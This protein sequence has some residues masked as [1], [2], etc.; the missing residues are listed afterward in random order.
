MASL[1]S[2]CRAA[3]GLALLTVPTA[4]S[5]ATRVFDFES[6]AYGLPDAQCN[7]NPV[8]PLFNRPE[9]GTQTANYIQDPAG[10]GQGV[11]GVSFGSDS[12]L[13][14]LFAASGTRSNEIRFSWVDPT[15]DASW[16]RLVTL[17]A[18]SVTPLF[19]RP[20]IDIRPGSSVSMN[21]LV[22]GLDASGNIVPSG[23]THGLE[24]SLIVRETGR[25][26]PLGADGGTN[27]GV[28]FVGIASKG[29][30]ED[31][32]TP[33]GGVFIAQTDCPQATGCGA[34]F[35]NIKWTFVDDDGVVK[36]DVSVDNGPATRYDIVNFAGDG[37]L[38]TPNHRA[39]LDSLAIR[40]PVNDDVTKQWFVNIDDIVID[41]PGVVD[42]VQIL[43]EPILSTV[44]SITVGSINTDDT[45]PPPP[46]GAEA[47]SLYKRT[48][49]PGNYTYT[50]L[51]TATPPYTTET[52][53]TFTGL[54]LSAGDVLVAR[55]TL[56]GVESEDSD[57]VT[58][59]TAALYVESFDTYAN[60]AEFANAWGAA[61]TGDAAGVELT[62]AIIHSCPNA[63]F[64]PGV[65]SGMPL[66]RYRDLGL[67]PA[68][69]NGTDETPLWFTFYMYHGNNTNQRNWVELRRHASGSFSP[70]VTFQKMYAFGC[71]NNG[72]TP[73]GGGFSGTRYQFRDYGGSG[74]LDW[75]TTENNVSRVNNAWNKMQIKITTS[76]TSFYVNDQLASEIPRVG[77]AGGFTTIVI[78]GGLSNANTPMY[79]DGISLSLGQTATDPFEVAPPPQ[80]TVQGPL[81]AGQT[82]VTVTGVSTG[83][84]TT[85]FV[86]A[87]GN[88]IGS[89]PAN[90]NSTVTVPTSPLT[91]GHAITAIQQIQSGASSCTSAAV[92]VG[93]C[94]PVPDVTINAG[95]LSPLTTSIQ[96][97]NVS[98]QATEVKVY[99]INENGTALI[100]SAAAD[101]TTVT[102]SIPA[103]SLSAGDAVAA[104]QVINT[105]EGCLPETT[106]NLPIAGSGDNGGGIMLTL[107]V[108][109][110]NL[111]GEPEIGSNAGG[112]SAV[113]AW[114]FPNNSVAPAPGSASPKGFLIQPSTEWQTVTFDP[115][116][117]D[118]SQV[119]TSG[120]T[121]TAVADYTFVGRYGILEHLAVTQYGEDTGP[122]T[123]YI[124]NVMNGDT[125]LE[126]FE[127]V[128]PP[129]QTLFRQPTFSSTSTPHILTLPS[130]SVTTTE[131]ADASTQSARI[132]FQFR[133]LSTSRWVRLTT[134]GTPNRP[135]PVIDLTQP[136]TM[137]VLLLPPGEA[138]R[139][140]TAWRSV[141]THAG[142]A[143]S[144]T[145]NP[146]ASGNGPN[147]PTV[148]PR[149]P[150]PANAGIQLIEVDFSGPVTLVNASGVTVTGRVTS[151]AGVMGPETS[152]VPISVSAVDADT[153]AIAFAP[154]QLPDGG[155]YTITIGPDTIAEPLAGDTDVNVRSLFGDVG[156]SGEILLGDALLVK[157]RIGQSVADN[158]GADLNL[159]GSID[160][161]DAL[162][163][164]LRVVSPSYKALCP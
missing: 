90:G 63:V 22:F 49:T 118:G 99:K 83:S 15:N 107:G 14:G 6:P 12:V 144:I 141:R 58:V 135:N 47:V 137:R 70:G 102:V 164:K 93:S 143:R 5:A 55:Q 54:T 32:N 117:A 100:G 96:V 24:F 53:H 140:I 33:N 2:W 147:G 31:P 3:A 39:V 56:G 85:V 50:L 18:G 110:A 10:C 51:A 128:V 67:G 109:D 43:G 29:S 61:N 73:S 66:R 126:D 124:D 136:I 146:T 84:G 87:N 42:P 25:N 44:T 145:L 81:A 78:G 26:V 112:S 76:T 8:P 94:E 35:H 133:D 161:V 4:V 148:E 153:L 155:C 38:S 20:T 149:G 75:R 30:G 59:L 45:T 113:I 92:V 16:L 82:S 108:R 65:S 159:N 123:L 40:K 91:A 64:F 71:Y 138:P 86:Y 79:I 27:G 17:T 21:V 11:L 157:S 80:V 152:F 74:A 115:T 69:I 28:E 160:L 139:T 52:T 98:A 95:P 125:V 111:P 104:T 9:Y 154:G 88:Q 120:L 37:I 41:A 13:T 105:V 119:H 132:R 101:G 62:S 127:G 114:V 116:K 68:G 162:I 48:G 142:V 150:N 121:G 130:E 1:R 89:A 163:A 158:V 34:Y 103:G 77:D 131:Q 60:Q 156:S 46:D 134:S 129:A 23:G 72:A 106:T 19:P 57:A 36:V 122:Y 151:A 97:T 7:N